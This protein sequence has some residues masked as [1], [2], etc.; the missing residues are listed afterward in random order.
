MSANAERPSGVVAVLAATTPDGLD[1]F[2]NE[3]K[4]L[5]LGSLPVGARLILRCRKDWRDA[6][7]A[8][9]TLESVTLSVGSPSGHT[10]RVR[11]PADSPITLDGSIHVLGE[12]CWRAGRVRYDLRW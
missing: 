9:V 1:A 2:Q 8:I 12:G 3:E 5:T 11:R 6:A 4:I 7:V 10:Y